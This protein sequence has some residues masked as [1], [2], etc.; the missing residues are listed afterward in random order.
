MILDWIAVILGIIGMY[1][2]SQKNK[3]GFI[4]HAIM[5]F[6]WSIV[7]YD[8]GIYGLLSSSI[9]FFILNILCFLRW[10]KDEKDRL[11]NLRRNY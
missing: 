6:L 3:Y 8:T 10:K 4:I 7:G 1:L 9:I 11:K 5:C 2:L